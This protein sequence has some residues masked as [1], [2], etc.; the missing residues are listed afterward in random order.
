MTSEEKSM[1]VKIILTLLM[2]S[3][4]VEDFRRWIKKLNKLK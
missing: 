2:F 1:I 4:F 3:I